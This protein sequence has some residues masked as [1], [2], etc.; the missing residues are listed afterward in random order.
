MRILSALLFVALPLEA[1]PP[2]PALGECTRGTGPA[3]G[4]IACEIA[5]TLGERS[6]P[7]MFRVDGERRRQQP[8]R[9]PDARS[10]VPAA[11]KGVRNL[12]SLPRERD[13]F[14]RVRQQ[15]ASELALPGVIQQMREPDAILPTHLVREG[16]ETARLD[17]TAG[18][19][20]A[21]EEVRRRQS[22]G[23][24]DRRR[25]PALAP[26]AERRVDHRL[27]LIEVGDQ[28]VA[29]PAQ[30]AVGNHRTTRLCVGEQEPHLRT[31]PRGAPALVRPVSETTVR[32]LPS[33][34]QIDDL[35]QIAAHRAVIRAGWDACW[36]TG[37][38]VYDRDF[39]K[40]AL[41]LAPD[42]WVAGF[43]HIGT[44]P[45]AVPDRP[46]PDVP[47]LTTWMDT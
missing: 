21:M 3:L 5:R 2:A 43:V 34:Q 29:R 15:P 26:R 36:L 22:I 27:A 19:A 7:W 12:H 11:N 4:E 23:M 18:V 28:D 10:E 31:Q 17:H 45:V 30:D 39:I 6:K 33:H 9:R 38:P 20:S 47:A 8:G 37:W 32:R 46:R 44:C 35:L 13:L 25:V 40:P 24:C 14:P 16:D 41:G 42:E 1:A